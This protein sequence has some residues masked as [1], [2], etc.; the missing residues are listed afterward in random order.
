MKE[1]L[2]LENEQLSRDEKKKNNEQGEKQ[3][4]TQKQLMVH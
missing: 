4:F 3:P 1:K 2:R